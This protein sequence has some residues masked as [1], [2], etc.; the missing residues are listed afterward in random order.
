MCKALASFPVKKKKEEKEEERNKYITRY[1]L[2]DQPYGPEA[3]GQQTF[4]K[5]SGHIVNISILLITRLPSK[6]LTNCCCH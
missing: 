4:C 6:L 1:L 2:S 3:R 5:G